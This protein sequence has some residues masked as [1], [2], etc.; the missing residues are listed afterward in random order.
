MTERWFIEEREQTDAW[1]AL[2]CEILP[3]SRHKGRGIGPQADGASSGRAGGY[4]TY[5]KRAKR[6]H[7]RRRANKA[8][9]CLPTYRRYCGWET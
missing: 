6:R 9:E 4:H 7:E 8:P 1:N 5:L 2:C 3:P